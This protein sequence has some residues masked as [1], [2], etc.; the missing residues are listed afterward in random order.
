MGDTARNWLDELR[1]VLTASSTNLEGDALWAVGLD[2][3]RSVVF[4][5]LLRSGHFDVAELDIPEIYDL[6]GKRHNHVL[7][8]Y[9]A[10]NGSSP[11][12][13]TLKPFAQYVSTAADLMK[14]PLKDVVFLGPTQE[15]SLLNGE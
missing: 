8:V 9:H 13:Q 5:K 6:P 4:H 3:S 11:D 7:F 15:V 10:L 1:E 14:Q 12:P 2:Q